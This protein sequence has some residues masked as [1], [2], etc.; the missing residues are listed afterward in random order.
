MICYNVFEYDVSLKNFV[1]RMFKIFFVCIV[2]FFFD[3]LLFNKE[4]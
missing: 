4:F 3:E 1:V 2:G